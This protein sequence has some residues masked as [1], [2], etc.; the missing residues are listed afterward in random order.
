M[1]VHYEIK[2]RVNGQIYMNKYLGSL[3]TI[4]VWTKRNRQ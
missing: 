3:R 4:T 1:K 2:I